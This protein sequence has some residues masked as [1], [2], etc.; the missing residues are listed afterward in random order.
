[1]TSI[2]GIRYLPIAAENILNRIGKAIFYHL[3]NELESIAIWH[4]L[5]NVRFV[6]LLYLIISLKIEIYF[7]VIKLLQNKFDKNLIIPYYLQ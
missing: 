5:K 4:Q 1:M 6:P 7:A 3:E 2:N